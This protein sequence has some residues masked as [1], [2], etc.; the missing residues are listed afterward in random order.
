VSIALVA[1]LD[2]KAE[3]AAFLASRLRSRGHEV[4]I[5][6][7]G[8]LGAPGLAADIDR[9]VVA[10]HGGVAHAALVARRDRSEAVAVM[11]TGATHVLADLHARGRLSGALAIGGG[12]GTTIGASAMRALPLG[13]PKVLLSTLATDPARFIGTSDIVMIPSVVDVAGVN[14][15]SAITYAR[16]ADALAGMVEGAADTAMPRTAPVV[17]ATMFGVTTP[18]V[19]RAKQRLEDAGCEVL[20]FHATGVGGRMMERLIEDGIVDAVL[21]ITTTEWADEIVGGIMP[22]GPHRLEA[23]ARAGLPQVI[24]VGATDMVNFGPLDAVPERFHG[25]CRYA[26]T[27]ASTLLRVTPAEAKTIGTAIGAKLRAATGP[28]TVLIP[29]RGVSALD[30]V[31]GP[32]EDP[33]ARAALTDALC[34]QLAGTHVRVEEHDLHINDEAFAD[35]LADHLLTQLGSPARSLESTQGCRT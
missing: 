15:I 3:D 29:L 21:D 6:D 5:I 35:A 1:A 10:A 28:T 22:G 19:L 18:C 9:E 11:T 13:L 16:A 2:T 34:A 26:H 23:A 4:T 24:S 14:R 31:G 33:C 30:A 7:V 8:V 12:A 32:F 27:A 20:V 17:A 25:R